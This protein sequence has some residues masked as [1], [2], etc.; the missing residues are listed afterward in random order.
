VPIYL[1]KE[2]FR[3]AHWKRGSDPIACSAFPEGIPPEILTGAVSHKEPYPR[4]KGFRFEPEDREVS[5]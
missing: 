3:C 1:T 2:C 4:D 5:K